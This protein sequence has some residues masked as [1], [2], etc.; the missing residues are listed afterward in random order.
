[1]HENVSCIAAVIGNNIKGFLKKK[2]FE[3]QSLSV[4]CKQQFSIAISGSIDNITSVI[5]FGAK[6]SAEAN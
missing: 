6:L 1:M 4:K 5:M 2:M 3:L